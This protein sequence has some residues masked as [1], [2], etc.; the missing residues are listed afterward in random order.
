MDESFCDAVGR[1]E[2]ESPFGTAAK[3]TKTKIKIRKTAR[4]LEGLDTDCLQN[5]GKR[6]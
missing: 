6:E 3:T 5:F 4:T 2:R 1:S